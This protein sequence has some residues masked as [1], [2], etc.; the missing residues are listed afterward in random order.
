[1]QSVNL[2]VDLDDYEPNDAVSPFFPASFQAIS[3]GTD[4]IPYWFYKIRSLHLNLIMAKLVNFSIVKS[5][6]DIAW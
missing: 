6:V 3:A 5:H 2:D 4:S 1:L